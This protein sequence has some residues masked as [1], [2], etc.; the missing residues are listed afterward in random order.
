MVRSGS[1]TRIAAASLLAGAGSLAVGAG[2]V[3]SRRE[4]TL[5]APVIRAQPNEDERG[6]Y[7]VQPEAPAARAGL[8]YQV[9]G[10]YRK[11]DGEDWIYPGMLA[12]NVASGP[13]GV[14]IP[15]TLLRS[16]APP[17]AQWRFRARVSDPPGAWS[18]WVEAS[19]QPA[20]TEAGAIAT[21]PVEAE[22]PVGAAEPAAGPRETL[23]QARPDY[24]ISLD[25]QFEY[26]NTAMA[27]RFRVENKG[28]ATP[29]KKLVNQVTMS[30]ASARLVVRA[31]TQCP[32]GKP[33]KEVASFQVKPLKPGEF[34]L[35]P[36]NNYRM[37][38]ETVG[39]GC[40]FQAELVGMSDDSNAANNTMQMIT[41]V[42]MLPDLVV[43]REEGLSKILVR[44]QGNAAAGSSLFQYEA[45]LSEDEYYCTHPNPKT[46]PKHV[47]REVVVPP[48]GPGKSFQAMKSPW[49]PF[50]TIPDHAIWHATADFE[51]AVPES[52]EGNNVFK[53]VRHP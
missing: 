26:E 45:C 20:Q 49:E 46:N 18:E 9:E 37:P 52:N 43:L 28:Q 14:E 41:K 10:S 1:I 50:G 17:D 34:A 40:R 24:A 5:D 32:Q 11:S 42:A 7:R 38:D 27:W 31:A 3:Q 48:L 25:W 51:K 13:S 33:W 29:D 47:F 30:Y 22:L 53:G 4:M 23:R 35:M 2:D 36:Q 39:K 16:I 12:A 8:T 44:N 15:S 6:G 19:P 21:G